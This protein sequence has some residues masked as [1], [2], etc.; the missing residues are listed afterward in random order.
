MPGS[1]AAAAATRRCHPRRRPIGRHLPQRK[2]PY[3]PFP[4]TPIACGLLSAVLSMSRL[5]ITWSASPGVMPA[6][7]RSLP[8]SA[9]NPLR[10]LR[11]LSHAGWLPLTMPACG[12]VG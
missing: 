3:V 10:Q 7:R 12:R 8:P 11:C 9:T 1:G 4:L 2:R 5:S 6:T